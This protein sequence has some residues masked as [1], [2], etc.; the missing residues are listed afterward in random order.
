MNRKILLIIV[1]AISILGVLI[2]LMLNPQ[3]KFNDLCINEDKWNSI[4]S[5]RSSANL[6]LKNIKFNDYELIIDDENSKIYYS[7]IKNS[8]NK[9]SPSVSYTANTH[10]TKVAILEDE[11]TEDKIMNNHEFKVLLYDN[12][13]YRIYG[14]YCTSFPMLNII[15]DEQ[16]ANGNKNIPM[17]MYLFS[18]FDNGI[19]RTVRSEG[20]ISENEGE[21]GVTNYKFSLKM[22]TP[23]NNER[24]N[25][26]SLLHM[27][28]NSEYYLNAINIGENDSPLKKDMKGPKEKLDR[29]ENRK[30]ISGDDMMPFKEKN[31]QRVELFINNEYIGLYSL[32]YNPEAKIKP[33]NN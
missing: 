13:T 16:N 19:N 8:T 27:K 5:S 2:V 25:V 17:N 7:V 14:L 32:S 10:N 6:S 21:D 1:L 28:P 24:D 12:N 11:I 15:Y 29:V 20:T 22:T 9:F 18:N 33:R 3:I 30:M 4:V 31:E 26:I 23:N